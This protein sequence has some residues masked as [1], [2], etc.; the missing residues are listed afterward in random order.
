MF[1]VEH[2]TQINYTLHTTQLH[3]QDKRDNYIMN[4]VTTDY[5]A[6]FTSLLAGLSQLH[7]NQH[8]QC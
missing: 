2:T 8:V 6:G 7:A 1:S 4:E 5:N 3:Y